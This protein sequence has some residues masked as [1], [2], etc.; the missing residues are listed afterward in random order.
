MNSEKEILS[1]MV[2]EFASLKYR[3]PREDG[4]SSLLGRPQS[5]TISN[6]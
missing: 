1:V 3:S 2:P 5:L 4:K 6:G